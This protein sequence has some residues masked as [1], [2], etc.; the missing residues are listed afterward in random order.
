M[1]PL[2]N[3]DSMYAIDVRHRG[4]VTKNALEIVTGLLEPYD[5][6]VIRR[7]PADEV[8]D[9][10]SRQ[11]LDNLVSGTKT[12]VQDKIKQLAQL[13]KKETPKKKRNPRKKRV[14]SPIKKEPVEIDEI[15]H[16]QKEKE[17]EESDS[18]NYTLGKK[19][20]ASRKSFCI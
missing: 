20:D 13:N 10:K 9:R 15:V 3:F 8:L 1:E 17:E 16:E 18:T 4:N 5:K 14:R 19:Q 7:E 12:D 6:V 2:D 11:A